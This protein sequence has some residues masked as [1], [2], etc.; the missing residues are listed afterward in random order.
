[1]EDF[2]EED[3]LIA[4]GLEGVPEKEGIVATEDAVPDVV[5]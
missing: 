1:L 5:G 2:S 3:V 4:E